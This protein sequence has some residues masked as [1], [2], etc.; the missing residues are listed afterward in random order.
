MVVGNNLPLRGHLPADDLGAD[1]GTDDVRLSHVPDPPHQAE[2]AVPQTHDGVPAEHERLASFFRSRDLGEH[3]AGHQALNHYSSHRLH[4]H[5]EHALGALFGGV[6]V[7]VPE[8]R[9]K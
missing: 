7:T 5:H 1:V 6:T 3:H 4:A 2:L 9:K 8:E